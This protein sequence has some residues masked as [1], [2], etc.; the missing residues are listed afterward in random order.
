MSAVAPRNTVL[1]VRE[2]GPESSRRDHDL[3]FRILSPKI[4]GSSICDSIDQSPAEA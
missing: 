3:A 1:G 2:A 4:R